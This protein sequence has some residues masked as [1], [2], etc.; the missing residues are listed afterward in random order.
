[1]LQSCYTLNMENIKLAIFDIDGTLLKWGSNLIEASTVNAIHKLRENGVEIL[2]ATGRSF[3]FIKP[4]VREVLDCDY[5]VTI[6]GGCLLNHQGEILNEH[7]IHN[8][9]VE[10]ITRIV[11]KY[12]ASMALKT[13]KEMVVYRD[14]DHFTK[15]Y[16][17]S[18]ES[19]HLFIDDS[20]HRDFHKRVESAKGCFAY[21]EKR[22]EMME[23]LNENPHLLIHDVGDYGMDIFS[24]ESDKIHGIEE[25]LNMAHITWENTIAFGDANNDLAMIEKAKIGVAMGNGTDELKAVADFVTKNVDE[26]GI[27]YA[28]KHFYLI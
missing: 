22:K 19:S 11:D 10:F 3:Y 1:M 18:I 14:Y 13:S 25:V 2:V 27:A 4:H 9:D 6:N 17:S 16:G 24:I 12:Q 8:E 26:G 5:Y 23:E 21:S 20:I 15:F 28:L 7:P